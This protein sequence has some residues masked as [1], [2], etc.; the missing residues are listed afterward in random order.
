[1][2]LLNISEAA[3]LTGKS[4]ATLHKYINNGRLSAVQCDS[5]QKKIDTSELLRVFGELVSNSVNS[6]DKNEQHF[7]SNTID[8][9][10]SQ[11]DLLRDELNA[12]HE[13]E[14]AALERE[15]KLLAMLEQ[16]T[17]ALADPTTSKTKTSGWFSR[18]FKRPP[19]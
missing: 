7:T 12:A 1:M 14:K 10:H 6:D 17:L 18:F 9:L 15:S 8:V 11:I 16:H 13:R 5:G 4:R 3:K 2:A 19:L